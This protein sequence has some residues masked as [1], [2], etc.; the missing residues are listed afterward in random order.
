MKFL[1]ASVVLMTSLTA[2][3]STQTVTC[4]SAEDSIIVSLQ[5]PFYDA[6]G[7]FFEGVVTKASKVL[8]KSVL[9]KALVSNYFSLY[10]PKKGGWS[11]NSD[12]ADKRA[13]QLQASTE[14]MRQALGGFYGINLKCNKSIPQNWY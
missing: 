5:G 10:T 12:T 8:R 4:E 11:I 3:S 14:S 7:K 13:M 1:L 6:D 9:K 2:F